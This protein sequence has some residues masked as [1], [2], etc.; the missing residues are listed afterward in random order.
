[1]IQTKV[2]TKNASG[3]NF[4]IEPKVIIK[5]NGIEN[6]SVN[7]KIRM[8]S[9]NATANIFDISRKVITISD[10]LAFTTLTCLL[11]I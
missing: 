2:L 9:R 7:K 6:K 5:P 1:M 11:D 3:L 10:Y 8:F 4:D